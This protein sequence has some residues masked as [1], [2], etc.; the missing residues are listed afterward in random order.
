MKF[1]HKLIAGLATAT[2][3]LLL[4]A[5]LSYLSLKR[6]VE[7]RQW[8]THTYQ[9]L[10]KLDDL[11]SSIIDTE[12]GTRNY[13]ADPQESFVD[14]FQKGKERAEEQFNQV[15]QLTA[16]NP[17]QQQA[18]DSLDLLIK[19]RMAELSER[20]KA[21]REG[22][23]QAAL[24]AI[25][26]SSGKGLM[27][28]IRQVIVGMRV[29]ENRLLVLRSGTLEAS[30][31]K[32][33]VAIVTGEAL[34]FF[35]LFLAGQVTYGEMKKRAVAEEQVRKLN[36]DLEGRISERTKELAERAR[37]L[38]RSNQE[39]Q[40]FA[41]VASHDLQEP[42]RTISSFTQLLGKRYAAQLD[43]KAR[44][45]IGFAVDGSKRMQ[46]L[47]DDLLAFSRV[48]TQGKPLVPIKC[49]AALDRVLKSLRTIIETSGA[50][51]TRGELPVVLADENQ[52][53]QLLQNLITNAIKFRGQSAPRINVSAERLGAQ[54]KISVQDNGIG[55]ASEHNERIFIIFQ[56]L[57]T[58]TQYPGTG[59]GLAICKKI[60]ERQGGRIWVEPS[61]EGG[62]TFHFT[63]EDGASSERETRPIH[64]LRRSAS[65]H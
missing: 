63:I 10:E 37:D 27:N 57:H 2:A 48:G 60:V 41:Y 47:I 34:G 3:A 52:L 50:V 31:Q 5:I 36:K 15:R 8:V 6:T 11:H 22:G 54:W 24:S 28:Q 53:C 16:D 55:I 20:M 7:D 38:E 40:Q 39:L 42:L 61:P 4:V 65:A 17:N 43:D 35:L 64:E 26:A 12:T 19:G 23:P 56:R 58:K 45:F 62:S 51:I 18:L 14:A 1:Q 30:S 21:R 25:Q 33:R 46:T 32:T 29:E 44:E 13:I 59:I 9:V 49:D